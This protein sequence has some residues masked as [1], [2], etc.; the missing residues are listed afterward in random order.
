[1]YWL[2]LRGVAT[3]GGGR[4]D[5]ADGADFFDVVIVV[6]VVGL[7]IVAVGF[8]VGV[9]GVGLFVVGEVVVFVVI[10]FVVV[11]VVG[12][13]RGTWSGFACAWAGGTVVVFEF[14]GGVEGFLAGVHGV[15][16]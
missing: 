13:F 10:E 15:V 7:V 9:V 12:D 16:A 5:I 6:E 1:L 8:A 14:T 3:N 2:A 11:E 4:H